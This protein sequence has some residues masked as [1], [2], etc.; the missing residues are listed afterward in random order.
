MRIP[1]LAVA[2]IVMSTVTPTVASA[3]ASCVDQYYTCLNNAYHNT[4][5]FERMAADAECGIRYF[6][7]LKSIVK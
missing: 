1:A 6:G 7:C 5:F 3:A 2:A 4:G